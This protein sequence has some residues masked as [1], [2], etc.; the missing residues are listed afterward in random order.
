MIEIEASAAEE[1][2]VRVFEKVLEVSGEGASA[3]TVCRVL[4][5]D[6]EA[7]KV[8]GKGGK[9]IEKLRR[10]NGAKIRVLS[11]DQFPSG[12]S[13]PDEVIEVTIFFV[14]HYPVMKFIRF[15]LDVHN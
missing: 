8:I 5:G 15:N 13:S 9:T 7:G 4:V 1:T 10:N 2:A 14:I 12:V 6:R 11:G 3:A